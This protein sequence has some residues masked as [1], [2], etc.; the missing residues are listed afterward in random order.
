MSGEKVAIKVDQEVTL[1][2]VLELP[3]GQPLGGA[4]ALHPHPAY[5]GSME[6]NVVQAMVRAALDAGWAAL[7]FNFRGVGGSSGRHD[8]GQGEQQDV[9]AAASWLEQ[10]LEGPLVLLGYSFG[11]MMGSLAADRLQGLVGGVWVSPPL[12]L[13]ELAPWP[14]GCGPL[15]MLAGDRDEYTNLAGL[16]AYDDEMGALSS[17]KLFKGGDHFWWGGESA[18]LGEIS[19][20]L[21]GVNK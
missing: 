21:E 5:G 1:E 17:L 18:L 6:N 20:F 14:T 9:L 11:S 8:N 4:L 16:K 15:L 3:P 12:V 2:G 19:R 7:R 10:R 13:G